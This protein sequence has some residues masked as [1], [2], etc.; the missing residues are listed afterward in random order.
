MIGEC[1]VVPFV[2][3]DADENIEIKLWDLNEDI[4]YVDEIDFKI[5]KILQG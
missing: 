2:K 3:N 4:G 5:I 1:N